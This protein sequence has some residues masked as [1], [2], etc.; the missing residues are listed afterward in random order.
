MRAIKL[1][2]LVLSL[3]SL[4]TATGC[5]SDDAQVISEATGGQ[6]TAAA[7]HVKEDVCEGERA[8]YEARVVD[9]NKDG[10]PEVFLDIYGTCWG[11]GA[12][13]HMNLFIKG[14]GGKWAPQFGFPGVAEILETGNAGYPDIAIGGPGL[15]APVWRWDGQAYALF[16]K[17]PN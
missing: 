10:Q 13:V 14:M 1:L 3:P 9:L 7:G 4:L 11:G 12:G 5:A 6:F 16:K 15:C 17:C 8:D 2:F